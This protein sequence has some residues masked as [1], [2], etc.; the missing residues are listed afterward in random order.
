MTGGF[1]DEVLVFRFDYR[2]TVTACRWLSNTVMT[3][4]SAAGHITFVVMLFRRWVRTSILT[5]G[6]YVVRVVS[7]TDV[8]NLT[9]STS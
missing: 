6:V 2:V 8:A 1:R 5:P 9:S 4:D 7:G 3:T